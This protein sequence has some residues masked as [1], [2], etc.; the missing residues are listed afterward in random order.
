MRYYYSNFW[1]Y[2]Q[3]QADKFSRFT[4]STT[5]SVS[6]NEIRADMSEWTE[7]LSSEVNSSSCTIIT[8]MQ[9]PGTQGQ[10]RLP[11]VYRSLGAVRAD[12]T[13]TLAEIMTEFGAKDYTAEIRNGRLFV[14][15]DNRVKITMVLDK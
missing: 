10:L 8:V 15:T 9:Q 4:K 11:Q 14:T 13:K 7:S 12:C 5:L 2:S 6:I 3:S 1:R